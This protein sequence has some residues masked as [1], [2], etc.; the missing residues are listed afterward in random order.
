MTLQDRYSIDDIISL[1]NRY[2]QIVGIIG[3]DQV[4]YSKKIIEHID[5]IEFLETILNCDYECDSQVP[6]VFLQY[7]LDSNLS[8]MDVKNKSG[9]FLS[10]IRYDNKP[11]LALI[12]HI[13]NK[14][15]VALALIKYQNRDDEAL[16]KF[17]IDNLDFVL[18]I[19]CNG[20]KAAVEYINYVLDYQELILNIKDQDNPIMQIIKYH[21]ESAVILT[22]RLIASDDQSHVMYIQNNT[23]IFDTIMSY[24]TWATRTFTSC[25]LEDK[26]NIDYTL[27]HFHLFEH[28]IQYEDTIMAKL[29]KILFKEKNPELMENICKNFEIIKQFMRQGTVAASIFV[30]RMLENNAS[31]IERIEDQIGSLLEITQHEHTHAALIMEYITHVPNIIHTTRYLKCFIDVL[32][33]KTPSSLELISNM[34]VNEE[35]LE[36]VVENLEVFKKIINYNT[37]AAGKLIQYIA[38]DIR[39]IQYIQ[40]SL[41][42]FINII[43]FDNVQAI[44]EVAEL[45]AQK[46]AKMWSKD[47]HDLINNAQNGSIATQTLARLAGTDQ[48]FYELVQENANFFIS[49]IK[50][51]SMGA[52]V[53]VK[54]MHQDKNFM[55]LAKSNKQFFITMA[56]HDTVTSSIL[57]YLILQNQKVNMSIICR[58]QDLFMA[59]IQYNSLAAIKMLNLCCRQVKHI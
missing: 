51:K 38:E 22:K 8:I 23:V 47:L 52:D 31:N 3:Y 6:L 20:T 35:C 2:I 50:E 10:I 18:K 27:Q 7:V 53:I 58:N 26:E 29:I 11:V 55:T 9:V 42:D 30:E 32:Q 49:L 14:N 4:N 59:I 39:I 57:I 21:N 17:I 28:L 1:F 24:D 45:F 37:T 5:N 16:A 12:D 43:K 25:L 44:I 48:E 40:N 34:V 41:D 36:M 54:C 19:I 15:I 46:S 56:Q 13:F 33:Y